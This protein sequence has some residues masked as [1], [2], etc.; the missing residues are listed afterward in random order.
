VDV[1]GYVLYKLPAGDSLVIDPG[2]VGRLTIPGVA[3]GF[4]A[5]DVQFT[6]ADSLHISP[7][8]AST[9]NTGDMTL[10]WNP[11]VGPHASVV[12]QLEFNANAASAPNEQILCQFTDNGTHDVEARLANIWRGA[13]TKHVHAYRFL[14][15]PKSDNA[16]EVVVLSQYSTDATQ[17]VNP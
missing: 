7:I 17:I 11:Q 14:T 2:S 10:T 5:F 13:V 15:T 6:T 4:H 16:Q 8:D 9:A 1:N 12:V 3:N